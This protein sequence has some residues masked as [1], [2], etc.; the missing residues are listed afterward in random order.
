[1]R[2]Y[3]KLLNL[4]H[5]V[6]HNGVKKMGNKEGFTRITRIRTKGGGKKG[7]VKN[8]GSRKWETKKY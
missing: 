7:L 1:M 3:G 5:Q 2:C 4:L 8:M 6:I